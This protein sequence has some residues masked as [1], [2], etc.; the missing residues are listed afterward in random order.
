MY[1]IRLYKILWETNSFFGSRRLPRYND[2]VFK[3]FIYLFKRKGRVVNWHITIEITEITGQFCDSNMAAGGRQY[4]GPVMIIFPSF[5]SIICSGIVRVDA[6][7][8]L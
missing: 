8:L 1:D 2:H 4:P 7:I 3:I 5:H 6:V